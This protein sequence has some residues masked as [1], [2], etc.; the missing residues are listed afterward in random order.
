MNKQQKE[1]FLQVLYY[2]EIK[3]GGSYEKFYQRNK[4]ELREKKITKVFI[5]EWLKTQE[6]RQVLRRRV[7][8]KKFQSI[9]AN[10]PVIRNN[11][12]M[13]LLDVHQ[14]SKWNRGF[15]WMMVN[16]DVY[17]RFLMVEP[18]KNKN[19]PSVLIA[20]KKITAK[21][22]NPKNLNTDLEKAVMGGVFQAY[23]KSKGTKHW[24]SDPQFHHLLSIAERVNR[25]IREMMREYFF[26]NKTKNWVDHIQVLVRNYN[27]DKHQTTKERPI[28]IWEGR[29][30]NRQKIVRPVIDLKVGDRV[31][32]LRRYK[33]FVK[34]SDQKV[35]SATIYKIIKRDRKRFLIKSTRE[36]D[37]DKEPIWKPYNELQKVEGKVQ[38]APESKAPRVSKAEYQKE[39]K[40]QQ[41]LRRMHK[42]GLEPS[43]KVA[44]PRVLRPRKKVKV[45]AK[46]KIAKKVKVAR[47]VKVG[48]KVKVA[49][50]RGR[51]PRGKVWDSSKGKWVNI[52]T[53]RP[54][55]RAPKGKVWSDSESRWI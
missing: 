51:A 30:E 35:F 4:P 41:V 42:E 36:K 5:K 29:S 44:E 54:R 19:A 10:P 21:Y 31:R 11:Y 33:Q 27:K 12:Q 17:S 47:K 1:Q 39:M 20:Y 43:E 37:K 38:R 48:A 16:I 25:T 8:P 6:V 9:I 49:R 40:R 3:G 53:G 50:P 46:V 22:G 18:M 32:F 52:K 55:G 34:I 2:D 14:W 7:R 23:L 13:D 28:D 26:N 24:A 15:K 45:G